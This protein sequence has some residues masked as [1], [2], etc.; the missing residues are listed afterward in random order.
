MRALLSTAVL[1]CL[2]PLT[3]CGDPAPTYVDQAWVRVSPNKDSPSA[4]YFT[5][6]GGEVATTLRGVLTDRAVR[7]EMHESMKGDGGMMSM[8]P[9][10]SVDIPAK[11]TV[12]FA[13]GGKHVML[14]GLNQDAVDQGKMPMTFLFSNGDR[15]IVDAVVQKPGGGAT[16]ASNDAASNAQDHAAH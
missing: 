8:K 9:I 11:G 4:A 7:A 6:H 3:A 10:D 1:T 12:A 13:P 2:L 14:W 5:V 15:I 16:P